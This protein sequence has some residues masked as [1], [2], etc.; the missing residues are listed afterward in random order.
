MGAM[1]EVVLELDPSL[2]TDGARTQEPRTILTEA[3][4]LISLW[5]NQ[6]PSSYPGNLDPKH[7]GRQQGVPGVEIAAVDNR[8]KRVNH[9]HSAGGRR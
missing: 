7:R 5:R 4:V 3:G 6:F 2:C 9:A 1:S 8:R